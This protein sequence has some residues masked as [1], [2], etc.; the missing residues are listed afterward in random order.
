MRALVTGASGFVGR[1]LTALLREQGAEVLAAGGP[2]DGEVLPLDLRDRAALAAA[3]DLAQPEVVFHLAAQAFV[4]QAI[5]DP[6][7]TYGVNVDGTAN[8]LA[9]LR[10]YRDSSG[11]DPRL[12]YVSSAEVY[13]I[14]APEAM[15]LDERCAT[16]PTNPYAASK[17]AAEALVL[18]EARSFGVR[19]VVTRAFNHIGPGQSSRF[20]VPAFASQLAKIAAGGDP[21]LL[22]GNLAAKRDFLDVRDVVRAYALLA[23]RGEPGEIYNVCSG[24]AIAMREVLSE[25]IRIAHVPVEVREDPTR[26]RPADVPL[27]CGDNRRLRE[28]TGWEPRIPLRASLQDIYADAQTVVAT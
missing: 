11:V 25:L 20:A 27:L 13:G 19:A 28:R 6:L 23:E 2:H 14:Q 18:G 24:T 15:P 21:V 10:A 7:E 1:R 22:V 8:L 17:A 4:P 16:N 9:A 5:A 26:M 3:F 12:L